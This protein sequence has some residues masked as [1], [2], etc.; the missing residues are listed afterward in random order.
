MEMSFG[1]PVG[2]D[3]VDDEDAVRY[4]TIEGDVAHVKKAAKADAKL[5]AFVSHGGR[6]R[7]KHENSVP[8]EKIGIRLCLA[9]VQAGIFVDAR[10][11]G[12]CGSG[13]PIG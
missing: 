10:Q 3:D 9:E 1:K 12:I 4:F 11:H 7:K 8:V 2:A 5:F 6:A 13:Q